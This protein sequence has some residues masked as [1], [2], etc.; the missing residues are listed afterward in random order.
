MRAVLIV[1]GIAIVGIVL[2]LLVGKP[3]DLTPLPQERED[4]RRQAMN[5]D[6][7]NPTTTNP[8]A[9]AEP[10]FTPPR[11]GA[12]QTVLSVEG[13]GNILIEMYP[14]AAPK[15]VQQLTSLVKDGFYNGIK[16]HRVEPGFVVQAGDPD[17]KTAGIDGPTIGQGGS[18]KSIPFETNNLKH[19]RGSVAMALSS[20]RSDTADSQWF[21]NLSYNSPLD[22]D[23]CVFGK[24]VQGMEVAEKIQRG[25][26]IKS[27]TLK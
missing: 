11:E 19:V 17:T 9:T 2:S 23:Y 27:F 6:A 3:K 20:A 10:A 8:S 7:N 13:K 15:T 25:D 5:A 21:I 24:V 4:Q 14:K 12:V 16:I 22:G 1:M 18:G 26:T